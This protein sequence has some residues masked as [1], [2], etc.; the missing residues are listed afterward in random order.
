MPPFLYLSLLTLFPPSIYSIH[1]S[2]SPPTP[3]III[4][5]VR[6]TSSIHSYSPAH[7]VDSMHR[8][9]VPDYLSPMTSPP[10][11]P[12]LLQIQIDTNP[13]TGQPQYV[14]P[15]RN[16]FNTQYTID[17]AVGRP[18]DVYSFIIDTGSG[19]TLL[20]EKRCKSKTCKERKQ[21]DSSKSKDYSPF[22]NIVNIKY[23]KGGV[24]IELAKDTFFFQDM[25][26]TNQE[27]G[28]VLNEDGL[29]KSA[30]YDGIVGF[31]YPPLSDG[32][33]PF[34]D[35]IIE[36]GLLAKNIFSMYLSR[37]VNVQSE[38]YLG[39]FNSNVLLSPVIYHPVTIRKWWTLALDKVLI[40][41]RDSGL[42][43]PTFECHIIMDTGSSLMASPPSALNKL[44]T[45]INSYSD[46]TN[47]NKFPDITF[48]ISG[49]Y[50]SLQAFEYVL[51]TA[52]TIRYDAF[53]NRWSK[54]SEGECSFA[55]S[56]F[57]LGK[58]SNVWIAGDIFLTKFM[59]IYDRDNDR[60]GLALAKQSKN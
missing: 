14:T 48:V 7:I 23:A 12:S 34:F 30:S 45:L 20:N 26:I 47:I 37:D 60:V 43:G 35:R 4:P 42:C 29:Y 44:L 28:V 39:G 18:D 59:A 19:T 58:E 31:S 56:M 21:F 32:T 1:Q 54:I 17:I 33:K 57:D 5:M 2:P 10:L 41:G 22:G 49:V 40:G 16:F 55:F 36:M 27:F 51:T 46:C 6:R 52:D 8:Y 11:P 38:L 50:Y 53:P 3:S 15:I 25:K 24:T 13:N 9:T